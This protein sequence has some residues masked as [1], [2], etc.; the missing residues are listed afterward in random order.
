[1]SKL[2]PFGV[3]TS[4]NVMNF[5]MDLF[6]K[7]DESIYC[8]YPK[9]NRSLFIYR[10]SKFFRVSEYDVICEFVRNGIFGFY[11]Y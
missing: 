1:M 5:F 2:Y 9:R 6:Q 11:F 10:R 8:A 4:E 7:R 3:R